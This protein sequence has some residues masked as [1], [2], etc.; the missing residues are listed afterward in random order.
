MRFVSIKSEEQQALLVLHRVRETLVGQRIQLI[1]TIRGHMAEFGVVAAQG[2]ANVQQLIIRLAD[3]DDTC[4]PARARAVLLLQVDQLRDTERRIAELDDQI[5]EQAQQ[6]EAVKRLMTIPGVG[7]VVATA[8]TTTLGHGRAFASGRHLAAWLGLV[9]GHARPAAR[10]GW[11]G[12]PKQ[13]MA[14]CGVC[15]STGPGH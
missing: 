1:N 3:P 11:S 6:D 12:S 5:K 2:A 10:N 13:A 14:I 15:W 8:I 7:P 9:P 4:I